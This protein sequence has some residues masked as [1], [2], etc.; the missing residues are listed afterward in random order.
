MRWNKGTILKASV[1][2]IRKLQKEQQKAKELENRQKRLE[3]ANRHL[4]LRI[5]VNQIINLAHN[6]QCDWLIFLGKWSHDQLFVEKYVST[7]SLTK[8]LI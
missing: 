6:T 7:C 1:D 4:L 2:Y 3:H 5:Q 8:T